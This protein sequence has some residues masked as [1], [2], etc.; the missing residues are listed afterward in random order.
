MRW[1]LHRLVDSLRHGGNQSNRSVGTKLPR[2]LGTK[3]VI[4]RL[5]DRLVPSAGAQEEYMLE[6]VNRMRTNPAAELPLLLNSND[7]NVNSALAYF[8]VNKQVLGQQWATL[9]PA[10]PLAWSDALYSSALAHSQ[11]MLQYDQQQHQFAGEPDPGTRMANAGY[12]TVGTFAWGENIF[13]YSDSVFFGHA[14]LAIDWGPTSTGIQ[15]PPGHRENIMSADF[16]Q[17]GIGIVT[18]PAGKQTGPLLITQ[19]FA[20]PAAGTGGPFLLGA[21]F[22][23]SNQNGFYDPGEG[24][25]GVTI[26]ITGANGTFSTTTSAAGGYQ[27]QLPVGSYTVTASGGGL[28]APL[29]E[30]ATIGSNNV[31]INFSPTGVTTSAPPPVPTLT[32][33]VGSTMNTMPAIT[34]TAS[35]G[36]ARYDLWA[37][38]VTAGTS[39]IIRQQN[40]TTTSFTPTTPLPAGHQYQ[41]WVEAFDS[42]GNTA[43]W[44]QGWSFTVVAPA[45][46]TLTA[47]VGSTLANMPTITWT[48]STGATRYD[49]WVDDAS[50]GIS[51]VI[52]QQNLTTTSYTPVTPLTVGHVYH[53][54]VEAFTSSGQG[55]GWSQ[56]FSFTVIAPAPPTLTAPLGATVNTTPPITWTSSTGAVLYD[57]WVDDATAGVSQL[58][59]QPSLTSTSFTP[60]TPLSVGHLYKAWVEA[61]DSNGNTGGWSQVLTFA[62]VAPAPPT[63]TAPSGSTTSTTPTITWTASAGA[64]LYDLWVN[65]ATAGISQVIR[66]QNLTTT[67]YT[68]TTPLIVG[69]RYNAWVEAFN[70]GGQSGGWSQLLTFAVEP[71]PPPTLIGPIGSIAST[72]PTFT[73]TASTGSAR[74]DLWVNDAT[75]GTAQVIRQQNLTTTS[76]TPTL[77]LTAGHQYQAWIEAFTS[78]NQTSGW[79]AVLAFTIV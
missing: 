20:G 30:A 60:T 54:W 52:R 16:Q 75:I 69:H 59:R 47:P 28:A 21:M 33:P 13:A 46:P 48:T 41:A 25:A 10:P 65:D 37:N 23:D 79:S 36:S 38:D 49:L 12:A 18:A 24:L 61:F 77:G 57:L 39:Q 34:W 35:T 11:L 19:D 74:Y 43:G 31:M 42:N 76:Y 55:S 44:S 40:L 27:I 14:G 5:E 53:A 63:L 64:V 56:L 22:N 29:S 71:S 26:T 67:S 32:G 2:S 58:I 1:F 72:M 15:N 4:E 50:A 17:V 70:S 8:N 3:L 45:P 7:A 78:N 62:V 51:Q 6:L 66:Q 68:P 9:T 73:W